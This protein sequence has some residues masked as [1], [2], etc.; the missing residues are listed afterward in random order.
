MNSYQLHTNQ[1]GSTEGL[2]ILCCLQKEEKGA[3]RKYI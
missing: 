3:K 1:P 2:Q